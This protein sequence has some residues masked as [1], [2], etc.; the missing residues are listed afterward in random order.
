VL[1]NDSGAALGLLGHDQR[2]TDEAVAVGEAQL[3][4]L[5]FEGVL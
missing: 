5:G 2:L 3:G 4:H 1:G